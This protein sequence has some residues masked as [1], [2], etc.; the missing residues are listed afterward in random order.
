MGDES[1]NTDKFRGARFTS[2]D[3]SGVT[4]RDCDMRNLKIAASDLIDVNIS[5]WVRNTFVVND[6]DVVEY[7]EAELNRR[8]PVR[9]RVEAT[10]SADDY[11]ATW[12]AIEDVWSQAVTRARRLPESALQE[13][14]DEEWSL[15]ETLRHLVFATDAWAGSAVLELPNPY[16]RLGLTHTDYPVADAAAIG[17]ELNAKPT[18]DEVLAVREDRLAMVRGIV[19]KLTADGLE[20]ACLRPP[21]PGYPEQP[22]TVRQ[23]IRVVMNEE[24]EHYRYAMRDL[25][26]LEE[27]AEV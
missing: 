4:F 27:K 5:G 14:V 3:F 9:A 12:N 13:R 15:V 7:V 18:F 24:C 1:T 11:R 10:K 23:C 26:V 19:E 2:V 21:A 6:V 17:I 20:R 25:A 16:H 8:Y 22:R